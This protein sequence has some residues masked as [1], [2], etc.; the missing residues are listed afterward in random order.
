M[1]LKIKS[2]NSDK[3][4]KTKPSDFIDSQIQIRLIF[5][6]RVFLFGKFY[7]LIYRN[8]IFIGL[9]IRFRHPSY[10]IVE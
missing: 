2:K 1:N 5:K 6:W 4:F 3:H 8:N 10:N 9:L 7:S